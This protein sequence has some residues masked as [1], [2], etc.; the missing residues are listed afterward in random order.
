M[1]LISFD[2]VIA[3]VNLVHLP[4][5]SVVCDFDKNPFRSPA[6]FDVGATLAT[7]MDNAPSEI[8][9]RITLV[10]ITPITDRHA[11]PT[12]TIADRRIP[13]APAI[14]PTLA[15]VAVV[16]ATDIVAMRA[17]DAV[18]DASTTAPNAC[19]FARTVSRLPLTVASSINISTNARPA[20]IAPDP[21]MLPQYHFLNHAHRHRCHWCGSC[22]L[23][24]FPAINQ[25]WRP[26]LNRRP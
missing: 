13:I 7:S 26:K 23:R 2:P 12:L 17:N 9:A 5:A 19:N 8:V 24:G 21:A 1:F 16:P 11:I 6:N 20:L 15:V 22:R 3:P 25:A 4:M 18:A 14:T 10:A